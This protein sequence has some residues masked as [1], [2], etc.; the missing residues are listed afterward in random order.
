M[1]KPAIAGIFLIDAR[2]LSS[3][4]YLT[5]VN[6]SLLKFHLKFSEAYMSLATFDSSLN[7]IMSF[8]KITMIPRLKLSITTA[9]VKI[10]DAIGQ[11][12][13]KSEWLLPVYDISQ[14]YVW[15]ASA[16]K[17]QGSQKYTLFDIARM[18]EEKRNNSWK[19]YFPFAR[20]EEISQETFQ[21]I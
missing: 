18:I 5:I 14:V 15:I 9:P 20:F 8:Q 7:T 1:S 6:E 4:K 17:D 19:F 11:I 13:E 21:M 16:P 3:S 10:F 2:L 12:I